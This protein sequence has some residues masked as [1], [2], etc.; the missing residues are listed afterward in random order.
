M[1]QARLNDSFDV[2][3]LLHSGPDLTVMPTSILGRIKEIFPVK[4]FPINDFESNLAR[5]EVTV[6]SHAKAEL[7]M[8]LESRA[9][10]CTL[11]NVS[12]LCGR[13]TNGYPTR[14]LRRFAIARHYSSA[15][16]A[17]KGCLWRSK[18]HF[19]LCC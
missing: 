4:E 6:V 16:A 19:A 3:Y 5:S 11:R 9:G 8:A 17:A 18:R 1:P 2:H 14:G 15:L 13:C 10:R 12:V 7:D